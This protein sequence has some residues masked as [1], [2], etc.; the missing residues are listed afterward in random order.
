MFSEEKAAQV[1]AYLLNKAGEPMPKIKLLS[2]MYL[3]DR[4]EINDYGP[5]ITGDVVVA[6]KHGPVLMNTFYLVNGYVRNADKWDELIASK[7]GN[8]VALRRPVTWP[9]DFSRMSQ[10]LEEI[11]SKVYEQFGHLDR[12]ELVEYTQTL[13]EWKCPAEGYTAPITSKD[14]LIALGK[15]PEDIEGALD[16]ID[17]CD[18][19]DSID[20][21]MCR[22]RD[23]W[24]SYAVAQ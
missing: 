17:E 19:W 7:G 6:M 24:I 23:Q 3:A 4:Q 15:S 16:F 11:L 2:L 22:G 18:S 21:Y 12:W 13:P 10:A 5:S 9:K 1:A 14:I 20:R 8:T